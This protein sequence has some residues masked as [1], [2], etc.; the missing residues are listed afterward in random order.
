MHLK[1]AMHV[2]KMGVWMSGGFFCLQ[3]QK[4]KTK[5]IFVGGVPTDMEEAPIREYFQQFG[6]VRAW[7]ALIRVMLRWALIVSL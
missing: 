3:A 5:K 2:G 6:E 7:W 4:E 1:I